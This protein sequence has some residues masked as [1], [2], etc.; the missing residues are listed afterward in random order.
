MEATVCTLMP[1]IQSKQ[2]IIVHCK[3]LAQLSAICVE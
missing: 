1:Q 2:N 3:R